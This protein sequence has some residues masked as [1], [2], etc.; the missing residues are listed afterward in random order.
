MSLILMRIAAAAVAVALAAWF[1]RRWASQREIA[2]HNLHDDATAAHYGKMAIRAEA[3]ENAAI[4]VLG[5]CVMLAAIG[6]A[7]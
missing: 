1:A 2:H 3:V 7:L 6:E 5:V 4:I